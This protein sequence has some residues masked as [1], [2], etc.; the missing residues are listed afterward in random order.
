[1][2]IFVFRQFQNVSL[3]YR[4]AQLISPKEPMEEIVNLLAR[5]WQPDPPFRKP[6]W[7][8]DPELQQLTVDHTTDH[9]LEQQL[10]VMDL[11]MEAIAE[12]VIIIYVSLNE[13]LCYDTLHSKPM[14]MIRFSSPISICSSTIF[15]LYSSICRT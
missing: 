3:S 15:V 8:F 5:Y 12:V 9:D 13:K 2:L 11:L 10:L 7:D 4:L 1:M 6:F 14:T